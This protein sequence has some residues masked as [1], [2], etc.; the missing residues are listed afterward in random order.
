MD[1]IEDIELHELHTIEDRLCTESAEPKQ[2][3]GSGFAVNSASGFMVN[4]ANG[5]AVNSASGFMVNS[6]SGFMV[7]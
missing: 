5:F 1:K 7:N 4:S 2:E 3:D 6:A